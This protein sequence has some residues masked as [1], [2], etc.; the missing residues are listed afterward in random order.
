[1][2]EIDLRKHTE[3]KS[4]QENVEKFNGHYSVPGHWSLSNIAG[5]GQ[6]T[7]EPASG[8]GKF[9][10]LKYSERSSQKEK[11]IAS[12]RQDNN[13]LDTTTTDNQQSANTY[14][15]G[16]SASQDSRRSEDE[17]HFENSLLLDSPHLRH[18]TTSA[19]ATPSTTKISSTTYPTTESTP[20]VTQV[21]NT[22]STKTIEPF[23]SSTTFNNNFEFLRTT[24]RANLMFSTSVKNVTTNAK[25]AVEIKTRSSSDSTGTNDIEVDVHI[26][27]SSLL[28]N[29][30]NEISSPPIDLLPP[31]EKLRLYDDA[32]TQ[33]PPIYYEWKMP[34]IALEPPEINN[35]VNKSLKYPTITIT[36]RNRS[37][38]G[39]LIPVDLQPP[40]QKNDLKFEENKPSRIPARDLLPP[41]PA[42]KP[43]G[44]S[45]FAHN[46]FLS[47]AFAL[48]T[49][50]TSDKKFNKSP[51]PRS[52]APTSQT[53][54][55]R[56][57]L[58]KL[59]DTNYLDLK[60]SLFIPDYT[61]PLESEGH[62]GS[63]EHNTAVNSFQIKIPQRN[64]DDDTPWYGEN[65]KCPECHPSFLKPGSCEPC[66]KIR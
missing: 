50:E 3:R 1:M 52:I 13:H 4:F 27:S 5:Y 37:R 59:R 7:S 51:T 34:S 66:I 25:P 42:H 29:R 60:K 65:D 22:H 47:S 46:P 32:T 23:S 40:K 54:F 28:S 57:Q 49:F 21:F 48:S 16:V 64:A 63:Y 44:I 8:T 53:N 9:D 15:L 55:V 58:N 41:L 12:R 30:H 33:G 11:S 36:N 45:N 62:R 19:P 24:S 39:I 17:S 14:D 56:G 20:L 31:F 61:F 18:S 35:G 2:D 6:T 26:P 10:H 38:N 43:H